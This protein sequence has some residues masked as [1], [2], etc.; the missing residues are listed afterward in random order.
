MRLLWLPFLPVA[1]LLMAAPA[2]GESPE[3]T[4]RAP[5]TPPAAP[6]PVGGPQQIPN[7]IGKNRVWGEVEA[8]SPILHKPRLAIGVDEYYLKPILAIAGGPTYEQLI[9]EPN[10]EKESRATTVAIARFGL[11]GRL[12]KFVTFRSEFERNLRLHGSGIWEGTASFSVRDQFLRLERW[13]ARV[14]GG[15]ILDDASVDYY[16]AH[17]SDLLLADKYT[18]DPLLWAGFN[19]GQGVQ[20][21]YSRWGL[22]ANLSYTAGNPLSTSTSYQVGGT[23]AGNARLVDRPTSVFRVGQPDDDT[24]M[25]VLSPS[26]AYVNRVVEAKALAQVFWINYQTDSTRDPNL[27][28]SNF[29]LG[30]KGKLR[31]RLG[32]PFLL[33]PF[34]NVNSERNDVLNN[35]S[36]YADTLLMTRYKA[37]GFSAGA[38]LFVLGRAGL[39]FQVA[40][41]RDDNPTFAPPTADT[42]A[43]DVITK[44]QRT[45]INGGATYWITDD[46][47]LGARYARYSRYVEHPVD[48]ADPTEIEQTFFFTLRLYL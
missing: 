35:T 36:G 47:A 29:K 30:I 39:G 27:F 12:G 17:V 1:L 37:L 40:R 5:P 22:H 28:G 38:D 46:V 13:G 42:P 10:A 34:F 4:V 20:T 15:I 43:H 45:Y 24:H 23:L 11:E 48:A 33:T 9:K 16:S 3:E 44:G 14:E 7:G 8:P 25:S 2:R 19:R 31:G 41:F 6:A 21:S 32:I 26:L 18:R